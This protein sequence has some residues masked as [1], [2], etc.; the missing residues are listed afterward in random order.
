[1]EK[2]RSDQTWPVTL[3]GG[4]E[5]EKKKQTNNNNKKHCDA[6]SP[7]AQTHWKSEIQS[8]SKASLLTPP[9]NTGHRMKTVNKEEWTARYKFCLRRGF[10]E[11]HRQLGRQ[12]RAPE[13]NEAPA[14]VKHSPAPSQVNI[15]SHITGLF[16]LIPHIWYYHVRLSTTLQDVLKAGEN[17]ER[18]P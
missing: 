10:R 12:T 13:E 11:T 17:T 5:E 4:K 14:N 18:K 3:K 8:P 16:T 15:K 9:Y 1:M 2:V 6:H 7:G